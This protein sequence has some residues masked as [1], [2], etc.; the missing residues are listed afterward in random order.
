MNGKADEALGAN[1][2]RQPVTEHEYFTKYDIEDDTDDRQNA[3]R[4]KYEGT[5]EEGPPEAPQSSKAEI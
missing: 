1:D 3:L 4:K 2:S 5:K